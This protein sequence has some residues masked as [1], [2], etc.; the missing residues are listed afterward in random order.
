MM[1]TI[2]MLRTNTGEK[3]PKYDSTQN[4]LGLLVVLAI[5]G[6]RLPL[7][8]L[9]VIDNRKIS[10]CSAFISARTFECLVRP[11]QVSTWSRA[12]SGRL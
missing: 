9:E 3:D 5:I 1:V 8:L 4:L 12:A 2:G 6:R 10:F 7:V 11:S